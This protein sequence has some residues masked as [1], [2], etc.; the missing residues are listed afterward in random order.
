[1]QDLNSANITMEA[2]DCEINTVSSSFKNKEKV[3]DEKN[4]LNIRLSDNQ[5]TK[6]LKFRL[7]PIDGES[8]TP[9]KKIHVH[10]VKVPKEVS[11]SGWKSYICIE[12]T[13]GIDR[14]I[15]GS[16]CP[17]CEMNR[18]A[19]KK[20]SEATEPTIKERW[21]KISLDNIP[22]EACI[23]RGIE[24]GAEE[25]GPKFWKFNIRKDKTD[26][27][28]QIMELYKTRLEES[29][30]EGLEDENILDIN[31][32]KDL[33]ITISL[34]SDNNQ[35]ENRTSVKIVDY[36][37]NKPLSTDVNQMFEWVND[38]KKWSDVFTIKPYDYLSVILEGE[39]PFYDK[40]LNKWVKKMDKLKEQENQINDIN[41]RIA[42]AE[43]M[44]IIND[45]VDAT[46]SAPVMDATSDELPF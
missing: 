27:K 22:K 16:K 14:N 41:Q 2:M 17:F 40:T 20:F 46:M 45:N 6:E 42:D 19:Y 35:G 36:G 37:K 11:P 33:K 38:S 23:V 39:I 9:F 28:G 26:P 7:L 4:Y 3:F 32:G 8:N 1:M 18:E 13:E 34:A 15:Y 25:D 29:R 12:K 5:T 30:E 43:A 21:K 24:R 44:V 31:T 10:T